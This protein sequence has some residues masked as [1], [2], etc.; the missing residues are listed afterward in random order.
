MLAILHS[1]GM[2]VAD[3]FKPRCRLEAENLFLRHQLSIALRRAP[4]R[5][6]GLPLGL[7]ASLSDHTRLKWARWLV[8]LTVLRKNKL[9][10]P[11]YLINIPRQRNVRRLECI[12]YRRFVDFQVLDK[13]I[14]TGDFQFVR[15]F[16]PGI[17]VAN[18][19]VVHLKPS[20][21]ISGVSSEFFGHHNHA[22]FSID[23]FRTGSGVYFP[24][25][26]VV[27]RLLKDVIFRHCS[28][29]QS[30]RPKKRCDCD[31]QG[32]PELVT[33]FVQKRPISNKPDYRRN[34]LLRPRRE[35]PRR[36][37]AAE[38]RDELAASH[39][40]TSS[41]SASSSAV[42]GTSPPPHRAA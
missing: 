10:C 20:Q 14:I 4:P 27:N 1:L 33:A 21:V 41:A 5:H 36:S 31:S 22:R 32:Q 25:E 11:L 26:E 13:D 38:Q 12:I 8:G 6:R 35:R 34:R 2:F 29:L 42:P 7:S 3:L 39:S 18:T 19:G 17:F 9:K 15:D 30:N 37:R 24:G 28:S 40:I 16:T 23:N